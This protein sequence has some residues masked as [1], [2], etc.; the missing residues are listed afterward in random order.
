[1]LTPSATCFEPLAS[2]PE[3]FF[4]SFVP[5]F[6]SL[7]PSASFF[8]PSA[9]SF[10]PSFSFW[11]ASLS[12]SR[13][14]SSSSKLSISSMSNSFINSVDAMVTVGPT[15]ASFTSA[16]IFTLSG[17]S[18]SS[19]VSSSFRLSER[20]GRPI[21]STIFLS[22]SEITFPLSTWTLLYSSA[23]SII[24][25]TMAKGVYISASFFPTFTVSLE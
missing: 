25:V 3:P 12:S 11:D 9:A 17:I 5:S 22:P 15:V 13:E 1:M 2:S 8:A 10:E 7:E 19:S 21:P 24:A 14:S 23:E 20:P 4:S 18:R 16:V 6:R